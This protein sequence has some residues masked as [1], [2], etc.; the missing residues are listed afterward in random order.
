LPGAKQ[1]VV[2]VSL[3]AALVLWM[4][5][6]RPTQATRVLEAERFVLRDAQGKVRAEI[7]C[8]DYGPE[9]EVRDEKGD[10]RAR[11]NLAADGS[12]R[13]TVEDKEGP[14]HTV[15]HAGPGK[16]PRP[17]PSS[18]EGS[19]RGPLAD[20]GNGPSTTARAP[21]AAAPPRFKEA[22]ALYTRM[23]QRCHAADGSGAERRPRMKTLPDFTRDSW[24]KSRTDPQL[25]VSILSGSGADM[26]AFEDRLSRQQARELVA[27]VRAFGPNRAVPA[28]AAAESDFDRQFDLLMRQIDDL[29]RQARGLDKP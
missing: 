23:C 22:E 1:A 25:L 14:V 18:K 19:A 29:R 28:A 26:P 12:L 15:L 27:V 21:Q 6:A 2:A 4:G 3:V 8:A 11:L 13:L 9:I 7:S 16:E 10:R 24:Q 17:E 20:Q 5:Q